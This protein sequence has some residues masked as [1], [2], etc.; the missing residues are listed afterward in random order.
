M[1]ILIT[2][3]TGFIGSHLS[4]AISCTHAIFRPTHAQLDLLDEATVERYLKRH[5]IDVIVNAAVVGGA[6][7]NFYKEG[8]L[9]DNLRMFY[10]LAR[11]RKQV[12]RIIHIGS[13]AVYDKRF[14]IVSV[15]EDR[16]GEKIPADPYGFYKY[17]CSDYVDHTEGGMDIRVFGIFGEGEDYRFRFISN[18]ICRYIYGLPITIKQNV[19]FD[20]LDVNDFVKIVEYF[21]SHKPRYKAYN[22]GSG[23]KIDLRTIARKII[24]LRDGGGGRITVAKHGKGNEYT[25]SISRLRHEFPGFRPTP[26]DE[27]LARLYA[28][29]EKRKKTIRRNEI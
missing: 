13:G 8:M 17:V 6:G 1:N 11:C 21:L 26:I 4:R 29:Y 2:G 28:W 12:K 7:R 9:G 22:V 5:A 23:T 15:S 3:S 25:P 16:F 24:T 18:A 27:S 10:T 20:Y 14:P 19:V